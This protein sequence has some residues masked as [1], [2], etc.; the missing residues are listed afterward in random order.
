MTLIFNFQKMKEKPNGKNLQHTE[1]Q[2][3]WKTSLDDGEHVDFLHS[4]NI[5]G[6]KKSEFIREAISGIT[7]LFACLC[8][9]SMYHIIFKA[10]IRKILFHKH[11]A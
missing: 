5:Y 8:R 7:I 1:T 6:M 10:H 2:L 9:Y 4:L 11:L 3:H